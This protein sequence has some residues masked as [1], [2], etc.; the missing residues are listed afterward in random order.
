MLKSL[1]TF[2]RRFRSDD[3]GVTAL[4]FGLGLPLFTFLMLGVIE[5]GM[6]LFVGTLVEGGLRQASRY[7]LTGEERGG[8]S[9]MEQITQIVSDS[10]LGFVDL[11]AA[12]LKV[13]VYPSFNDI[14]QG[15]AFIDG[16]ANGSYDNGETFTDGNG[17]GQRDDDVGGEGAGESGDVVVYSID[18]NWNFFTPLASRI[19]GKGGVFPLRAS[20]A[21]RNEPWDTGGSS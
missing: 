4:E 20:I 6:V 13:K 7:G 21:V 2:M 10:T 16:N 8:I 9:R 19:V 17:N 18:Y 11:N 1:N 15:E 12:D 3:E 5:F 14:G